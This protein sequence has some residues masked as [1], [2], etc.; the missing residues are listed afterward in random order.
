MQQQRAHNGEMLLAF[1]ITT[2]WIISFIN[3]H[4]PCLTV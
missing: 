1:A 3:G 4:R 2:L